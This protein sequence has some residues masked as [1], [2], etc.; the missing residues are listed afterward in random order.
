MYPE[1]CRHL[2]GGF[3]GE[4]VRRALGDMAI[5]VMLHV[6]VQATV[7]LYPVVRGLAGVHNVQ[8]CIDEQE[9]GTNLVVETP[10][11]GKQKMIKAK[12]RDEL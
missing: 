10:N 6:R 8:L 12:V 11:T 4:R 5:Q 2:Q 3:P 1:T 7:P 9:E